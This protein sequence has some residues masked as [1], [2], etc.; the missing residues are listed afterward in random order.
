MPNKRYIEP[1]CYFRVTNNTY[2]IFKRNRTL[3]L[4]HADVITFYFLPP[5]GPVYFTATYFV[6][7]LPRVRRDSSITRYRI[8]NAYGF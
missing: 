2:H 1:C 3:L 4:A 7:L 5:M 8:Y 6:L